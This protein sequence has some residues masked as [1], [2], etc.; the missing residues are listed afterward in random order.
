MIRQQKQEMIEKAIQ[1]EEKAKS[2]KVN[3]SGSTLEILKKL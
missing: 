3:Q 2:I 1:N